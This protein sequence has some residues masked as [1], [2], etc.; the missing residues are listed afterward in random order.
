MGL[1]A[2]VALLGT[3]VVGLIVFC[4]VIFVGWASLLVDALTA[5]LLSVVVFED[6]YSVVLRAPRRDIVADLTSEPPAAGAATF[7]VEIGFFERVFL[8]FGGMNAGG[9]TAFLGAAGCAG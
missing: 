7:V 4:V 8:S 6:L 2:N 5:I 1:P 3:P 9:A